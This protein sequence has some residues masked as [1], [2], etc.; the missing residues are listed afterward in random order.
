MNIEFVLASLLVI[1]SAYS[2][3]TILSLIRTIQ[4]YRSGQ[5]LSYPEL[6]RRKKN[7]EI[8]PEDA[9]FNVRLQE[10]I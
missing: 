6:L 1:Y 9:D 8:T 2:L 4:S 3:Y 10:A 7:S 5:V